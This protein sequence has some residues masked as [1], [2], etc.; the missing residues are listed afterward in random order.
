[1]IS[2]SVAQ[3]EEFWA[4]V[5]KGGEDDCWLWTGLRM[6]KEKYGKF[7]GKLAHR[8][9][10]ELLV[11]EIPKGLTLDHL[12]RV[13]HCVKPRH[14]EPVT[15]GENVRRG[16]SPS[17]IHRRKSACPSCHQPYDYFLRGV[18]RR[19]RRCDQDR[20]NARR[21]ERRICA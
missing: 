9:A 2:L 8:I 14:L 16:E 18:K 19:C 6:K 1:M 5:D 12:C 15:R 20:Q 3:R 21:Q 7:R 4:L 17:S 13:R 10:Y 11:G